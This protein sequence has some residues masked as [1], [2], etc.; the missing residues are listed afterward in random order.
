MGDTSFYLK[1]YK[2][3][4]TLSYLCATVAIEPIIY[5]TDTFILADYYFKALRCNSNV[6]SVFLK[7][8]SC[9]LGS[10]VLVLATVS[11]KE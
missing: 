11:T 1:H 9:L 7:N 6:A 3:R 8:R 5:C 10:Q 2:K 4:L